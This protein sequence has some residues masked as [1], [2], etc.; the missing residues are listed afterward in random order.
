MGYIKNKKTLLSLCMIVKDEESHLKSCL[1]SVKDLVDEVIVVDTGSKDN[2][3]KIAQ[4]FGAK[5]YNYK[6][7]DDF[8]SARN[9]SLKYAGGD[10]ILVLDADERIDEKNRIKVKDLIKQKGNLSYYLNFKSKINTGCMGDYVYNAHPRLFQN[11]RGIFYQGRIHEEIISSVKDAGGIISLSDVEVEH[12][13]Y[14]EHLYKEKNKAK[15]NIKILMKELNDNPDNGM[16]YFYLGESYSLL[17]KWKKAVEYY[18]KGGEK[19]NIPDMNRAILYQNFGTALLHLKRYDEAIKSETKAVEFNP[20]ITTPHIVSAQA[21]FEIQSYDKSIWEL[22]WYLEK[23]NQ[24]NIKKN[25]YI[26]FHEPSLPFVYTLL[27]KAYLN[28]NNFHD[29]EKCFLKVIS[30]NEA[31]DGIFYLLYKTALGKNNLEGAEGYIKKAINLNKNCAGYYVELGSILGNRKRFSEAEEVF[32]NALN[33]DSRNKEAVRGLGLV[34]FNRNEYKK[35]ISEFEKIKENDVEILEFLAE[36]YYNVGQVND[37][38]KIIE[39]LLKRGIRK[40]NY[41]YFLGRIS[42]ISGEK[43]KANEFYGQAAYWENGSSELY[44][45]AGNKLLNTGLF[46]DAICA[47]NKSIR[48]TPQVKEPRMNLAL[49]YIKMRDFQKAIETYLGLLKVDPSD[50]KVK[51]NLAAL[52]GKIGDIRKSEKYLLESKE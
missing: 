22:N 40:Q 27:G 16:T 50:K 25:N 3:V 6:W 32:K 47:Y 15:R 34:Y 17:H 41:Y 13:G 42:E 48:L 23:I 33:V 11:K 24:K 9:E 4:E 20:Y 38:Q 37:A 46:D 10:W 18:E 28:T 49:T 8:S 7:N 14:E 26:I 43:E 36:S 12:F 52:Y 5:V 39:S 44:F 30:E 2:T 21:A 19:E 35:A 29:A 31:S 1:E 51:R 45:M